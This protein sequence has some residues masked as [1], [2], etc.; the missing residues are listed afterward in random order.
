M[1]LSQAQAALS[2][3]ASQLAAAYPKTNDGRD[4]AVVP[5]WRSPWGVAFVLGPVLGILSGFVALVLLMA[6]ANVAGLLLARGI[7]RRRE[8]ALRLAVGASRGR[9][10]R[11]LL[12]E[13]LAVGIIGGAAGLLL[14]RWTSGLLRAF[15]PRMDVQLLLDFPVEAT[16]MALAGVFALVT[17]LVAGL[18]PA[19]QA[20]RPDLVATLREETGTIAGG[21]KGLRLRSALTVLQVCLSLVLLVAAVLFFRSVRALDGLE[22]GFEERRMLLAQ[23]EVFPS[24]YDQTAA[25]AFG[26]RLLAELVSVPGVR[27]AAL[28]R[29]VPLGFSGSSSTSLEIEGYVKAPDEDVHVSFNVV[30]PDYFATVG[31]RVLAGRP[32]T[33]RDRADSPRVLIVNEAMAN[34]YW[35]DGGPIGRRARIDNEW[36]EIVGVVATGKYESVGERPRPFMYFAFLQEPPTS[37]VIHAATEGDPAAFAVTLRTVVARLDS[38]LALSDVRTMEEHLAI[39]MLPQ[40]VAATLVGGF[41]VLALILAIVGLYGVIAYAVS[42]RTRELGVRLALGASPR[43]LRR[44]VVRQGLVLSGL[45]VAIGLGAALAASRALARMLPGV[46]PADPLTYAVVSAAIVA[47]AVGASLIPARRAAKVDPLTA[48]RG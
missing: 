11:Q 29:R 37:M 38:R 15:A 8:I 44:L 34:R 19:L 6:C 24:G 18:A 26:E 30:S 22:L 5:T 31:A 28:A 46:D 48:L 35:P 17:G 4:V 36:H 13:S 21:L 3:R 10:V 42:Q 7:A 20:S 1:T 2:A 33:R 12:V 9:I 43:D 45:G 41:G 16:T 23:T 14:T 47:I 32:F 39:S 40:R 27:H 25:G